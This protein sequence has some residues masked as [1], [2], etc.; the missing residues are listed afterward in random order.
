MGNFCSGRLGAAEL[1]GGADAPSPT[2]GADTD[3]AAPSTAQQQG[4]QQ[5]GDNSAELKQIL[6]CMEQQG[7]LMKQLGEF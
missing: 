2:G 7:D 5:A 3:P 6:E 1:T 4:Q